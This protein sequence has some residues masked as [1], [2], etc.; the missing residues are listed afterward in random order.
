MKKL[1][2]SFAAKMIAVILLCLLVLASSALR[3]AM[4][5]Y[6]WDAYTDSYESFRKFMVADRAESIVHDTGY[7]YRESGEGYV[8]DPN[9]R[10][11]VLNADGEVL[12]TNYEGEDT[13]WQTTE[14]IPTPDYT[15]E[16]VEDNS[17]SYYDGDDHDRCP[18]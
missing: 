14:R 7:I 8:S 11:T 18:R 15:L 17:A 10:C 9:L 4:L 2:G 6:Q 13:L 3:S 12:W 1:Y 16:Y 5:L